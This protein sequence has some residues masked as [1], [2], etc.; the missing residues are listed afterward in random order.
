VTQTGLLILFSLGISPTSVLPEFMLHLLLF[1]SV[2]DGKMAV[3]IKCS[4]SALTE[5]NMLTL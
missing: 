2:A 1:R 5:S 3:L 4:T